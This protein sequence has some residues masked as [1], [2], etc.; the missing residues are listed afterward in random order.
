N[1]A[2]ALLASD[3]D[4][5]CYTAT[6]DLRPFEAI[7]E[8]CRI[9][10]AGKDVVCS[11]VVSLVHPQSFFP[12]VG[13]KLAAACPAGGPSFFLVCGGSR[14]CQR[15]SSA[16]LVGAV[17]TLGRGADSRNHQLHHLQS[18]RGPFRDHGFRKADG[19]YAAS[20]DTGYTV[21]CMGRHRSLAGRRAWGRSRAH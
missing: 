20:P 12:G 5:V 21:I 17:R 18:T 19:S 6:A 9:L 14:L 13:G 10:A 8:T 4:C 11:S 3:A 7:E 16:H 2:E 15:H 1:D